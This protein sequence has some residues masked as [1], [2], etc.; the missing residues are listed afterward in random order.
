[1]RG[2]WGTRSVVVGAS[3]LALGL[4]LAA[5]SGSSDG[6][7]AGPTAR[8]TTIH[9]REPDL[10]VRDS[11]YVVPK[12]ALEG[13]EPATIAVSVAAALLQAFARES[14]Q[15]PARPRQAT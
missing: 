2:P 15:A 6:G 7:S 1:M 4:G 13:K 12:D 9:T 5:C 10:A 3:V 14:A 11:T 8:S